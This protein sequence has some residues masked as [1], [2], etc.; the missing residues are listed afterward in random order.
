M[1]PMSHPP[2]PRAPALIRGAAACISPVSQ[3]VHGQS[4]RSP[5]VSP[6]HIKPQDILATVSRPVWIGRSCVAWA[7]EARTVL[8]FEEFIH[9]SKKVHRHLTVRVM[10][11]WGYLLSHWTPLQRGKAWRKGFGAPSC[12][13][14]PVRCPG[15]AVRLPSVGR[16][17]RVLYVRKRGFAGS[18]SWATKPW[19]AKSQVALSSET[20]FRGKTHLLFFWVSTHLFSSS[21][22]IKKNKMF[23][24]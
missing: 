8:S 15:G 21:S 1:T 3:H 4:R 12:K 7:L 13:S 18:T 17:Q 10:G 16:V 22:F 2:R 20:N 6:N 9:L 19:G 14:F 5:W 11:S 24:N 23:N